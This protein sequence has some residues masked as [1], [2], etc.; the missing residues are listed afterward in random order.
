LRTFTQSWRFSS[1]RSTSPYS[2][3]PTIRLRVLGALRMLT[4]F[5]LTT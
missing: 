5:D 4:I 2:A 3:L 1:V